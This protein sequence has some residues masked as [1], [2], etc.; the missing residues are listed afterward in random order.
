MRTLCIAIA[1]I[2]LYSIA[3]DSH[4]WLDPAERLALVGLVLYHL[5]RNRVL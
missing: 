4:L 1:A 3:T 2:I 5:E